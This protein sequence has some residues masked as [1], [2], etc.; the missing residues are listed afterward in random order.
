[1]MSKLDKIIDQYAFL[2]RIIGTSYQR[3]IL[4][5]E[6]S[7]SLN[8]LYAFYN[9]V[10]GL[11]TDTAWF[12]TM[13]A[14][15]LMLAIMRGAAV[16]GT[17]KHKKK[18]ESLAEINIMIGSGVML[19]ILGFV[20][21]GIVLLMT[22]EDHTKKYQ[23]IIML[24]IAGYTFYKIISSSIHFRKA[25]QSGEPLLKT[26]RS[27]NIADAI[28]SVLNLE[29]SLISGWVRSEYLHDMINLFSGGAACILIII[30]GIHLIYDAKHENS[31]S[32]KK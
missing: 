4:A 13:F 12:V 2:D 22:K 24:I 32:A 21:I 16:L 18:P 29:F 30:F 27:I 25:H 3:M 15:Y 26:I 14:Y 19:V 5:A 11:L 9:G 6:I 10:I 28:V 7:L 23:E 8:T 20:M 31:I 17:K 1:M